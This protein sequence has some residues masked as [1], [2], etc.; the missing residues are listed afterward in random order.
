MTV[1]EQS[2]QVIERL[3]PQLEADGYTIYLEPSRQL[4]PPFMQGYIP[5]AIALGP[6]KNLAIEVIVEGPSD[7]RSSASTQKLSQLKRRFSEVEDWELR[8]FFVRPFQAQDAILP[9]SK[10]AIETSLAS[11]KKLVL[12]GQ[13]AP[14]LL[15]AWAT[16]EALARSLMPET[17]ARA[18]SPR[19]LVEV[20][21]ADGHVTPTEADLL[22]RLA[23]RR[24]QIA[25]GS[26]ELGADDVELAGFI[27]VLKVLLQAVDQDH[28]PSTEGMRL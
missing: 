5:D 28:A 20:L 12:D 26:L 23:D 13:Q 15:I 24:N 11:V 2:R 18:Q 22:R 3:I 17:F 14:A 10:A 8:V 21:A 6:K 19:R 7:K 25:H 27:D 4:L 16:L 9:I 1:A